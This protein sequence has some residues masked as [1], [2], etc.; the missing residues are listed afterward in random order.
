MP[1]K[2]SRI[3][4]AGYVFKSGDT[5]IAF[6][7][8]FENPFSKNCYAFPNVQ[9]NHDQIRKEKF[10]AV[11]IS[12]FHDDHCSLESLNLLDR[13]TPIYIYCLHEELL[14]WIREL[15]FTRV[16][17]LTIDMP[18]VVGSIEVIPRRALDADVDSLFHIKAEGLNVLN[19]VDS[20]IDDETLE[21]LAQTS[22]DMILWPFQTMRELEVIAPSRAEEA[23]KELPAEWIEQ[24]TKLNPKYVVPSSCQF[25][26]ESWSW[27]NHAFFPITYRQFQKEAEF[28]LPQSQVV[29]LNPSVSVELDR[30]SLN[31]SAP[32]PWI[33][34]IGEQDVDYDYKRDLKI[35]S[36]AEVAQ[37]FAPLTSKQ[38][39]SVYEYCRSGLIAKYNSL[40]SSVDEY[41]ETPRLWRLSIYDHSGAVLHFYYCLCGENIEP[42]HE[43]E[44]PLA[45]A[46]EVSIAKLYGALR[47]GETLTSM[48][49]RINDVIFTPEIEREVQSVDIIEDPLIR[50]LF[51]GTFGA[52]QLA[53]L[54]RL[55]GPE[56]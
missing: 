15:R 10:T 2:I 51:N 9:F 20:W 21:L 3:L 1:L 42:A 44:G 8:I 19:V 38:S 31:E 34:P 24:L 23:S 32:L 25:V 43:D 46:T 5:Q 35:P 18:V 40:G 55:K 17:P 29:R 28:A 33:Q 47:C 48:Y 36:T 26:Q 30:N 7:P 52:Y 13:E 53:Q 11:F 45:W 14:S 6:D 37:N 39:E 54:E 4:H 49:I 27:Y 56:A 41:F 16:F 50:V 12:H 22:W